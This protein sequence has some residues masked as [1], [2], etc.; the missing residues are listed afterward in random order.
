MRAASRNVPSRFGS[1]LV[2][3]PHSYDQLVQSAN[4]V[5][6]YA[7][8]NSSAAGGAQTVNAVGLIKEG[9]CEFGDLQIMAELGSDLTLEL[10]SPMISLTNPSVAVRVRVVEDCPSGTILVGD[11]CEVCPEGKYLL[12]FSPDTSECKTCPSG[13]NCPGGNQ[14]VTKPGW[15]RSDARSD[16][17]WSCPMEQNCLGGDGDDTDFVGKCRIGSS[18]PLCAICNP[19]FVL[20]FKRC[21]ECGSATGT[22]T[23]LIAAIL[24][25]TFLLFFLLSRSKQFGAA[26]ESVSFSIEFKVNRQ[27]KEAVSDAQQFTST[28]L[29][30]ALTDLFLDASNTRDVRIAPFCLTRPPPGLVS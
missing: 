30:A 13:A 25:A 1:P 2:L 28:N 27:T 5:L 3:S 21:A 26:M 15:W 20:R 19:E 23:I 11:R 16:A 17:M 18:G 24:I 8:V 10:T 4:D 9:R 22:R 14:L 29:P 12:V 7:S 6:V